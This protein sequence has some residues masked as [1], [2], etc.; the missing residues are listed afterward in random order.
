MLLLTHCTV[1]LMKREKGDIS[2][3][4]MQE[5]STLVFLN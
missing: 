2:P 1:G 4:V 5:D 3:K